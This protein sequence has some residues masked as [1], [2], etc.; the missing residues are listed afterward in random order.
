MLFLRL[1]QLLLLYRAV[2]Y[3]WIGSI[4]KTAQQQLEGKIKGREPIGSTALL[5]LCFW[6]AAQLAVVPPKG[7]SR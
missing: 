2:S 7:L 4:E 1:S 3:S 6:S 5:L